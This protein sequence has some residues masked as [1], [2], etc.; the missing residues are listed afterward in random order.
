[1]GE[2]PTGYARHVFDRIDS[3]LAEAARMAPTVQEPTWIMAIEQ[4]AARGRRG[5]AW[6]T[7]RGNFAGTLIMPMAD[8]PAQAALRSFVASLALREALIACGQPAERFALKWPNDVLCDAGK[9]AGILLESRGPH[10][11]IGI[12]VNLLSAPAPDTVE[13]GALRPVSLNGAVDPE[14]FL[15]ALA[16]AFDYHETRM[17]THGFAPIRTEWLRHAARLGEVI[18]AR[19]MREETIGTFEDVDGSGNLILSTPKGRVAISAADVYF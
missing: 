5:R 14:A 9:L 8:P 18:T 1:M 19:T 16:I 15:D 7:P 10:L 17:R 4:T 13:R 12:G 2:W 3:T 11:M 6:A